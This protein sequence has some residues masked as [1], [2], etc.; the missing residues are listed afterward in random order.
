M[1][2]NNKRI[3]SIKHYMSE[4]I[5]TFLHR[6]SVQCGTRVVDLLWEGYNDWSKSATPSVIVAFTWCQPPTVQPPLSI[7]TLVLLCF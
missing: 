2:W 7:T 5:H 6:S 1:K 4:Y 3:E